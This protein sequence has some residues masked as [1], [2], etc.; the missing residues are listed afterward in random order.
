MQNSQLPIKIF[1]TDR[2]TFSRTSIRD[3][4][5]NIDFSRAVIQ[6]GWSPLPPGDHSFDESL[7]GNH[8]ERLIKKPSFMKWKKKN[9][10]R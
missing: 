4:P 8:R 2:R 7:G 3:F 1:S 10:S 5:F 9:V 6:G